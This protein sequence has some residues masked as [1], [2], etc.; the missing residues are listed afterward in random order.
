MRKIYLLGLLLLLTN[1]S[2]GQQKI[3][4]HNSGNTM[5]AK[6]L[7]AVDSIKLESTYAKFKLSDATNTLNIQKTMI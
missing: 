2:F 3:R 5:Y 7:T 1:L 4:V 6:E